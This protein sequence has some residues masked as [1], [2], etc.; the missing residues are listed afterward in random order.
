MNSEYFVSS[1]GMCM[2]CWEKMICPVVWLT[3]VTVNPVMAMCDAPLEKI[4]E[5]G[6]NM[7]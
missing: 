6:T 1:R 5:K 2:V 3:R 4:K 7:N